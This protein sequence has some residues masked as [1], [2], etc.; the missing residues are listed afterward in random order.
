MDKIENIKNINIELGDKI[1]LE[2]TRIETVKREVFEE[3]TFEEVEAPEK[4][5]EVFTFSYEEHEKRRALNEFLTV[6][7]LHNKTK[8]E[9]EV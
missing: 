6:F 4:V 2:I 5:I 8:V 9:L 7:Q 1:K 3:D